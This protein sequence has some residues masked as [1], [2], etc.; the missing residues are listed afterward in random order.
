MAYFEFGSGLVSKKPAP[1]RARDCAVIVEDSRRP[2]G[3][4]Q[5][6]RTPVFNDLP[7]S[8]TNKFL[9]MGRLSWR[10]LSFQTKRADTIGPML[11]R[12]IGAI[13]C[14]NKNPAD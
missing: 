14:I 4:R 5:H 10:P 9:F 7:E 13:G 3:G 1:V 6:L 2:K 8:R 12:V 11:P